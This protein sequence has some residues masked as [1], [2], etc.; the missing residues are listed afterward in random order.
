[1]VPGKKNGLVERNKSKQQLN[2]GLELVE[3]VD[4]CL[5]L[6]ERSQ[7]VAQKNLLLFSFSVS[8]C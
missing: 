4:N 2:E 1:M 3:L 6:G 8:L 5:I 7:I